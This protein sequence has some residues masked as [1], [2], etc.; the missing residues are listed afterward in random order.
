MREI[1]SLPS[2]EDALTNQAFKLVLTSVELT[3]DELMQR[4]QEGHQSA[5]Q[6]L[7]DRHQ[8]ALLGFFFRQTR[9][10]QF[11]ED[12]TQETLL[13]VYN[14]HWDYLPRGAFRGWMFR[15]ARNLLI[16][17]IRRRHGDALVHSVRGESDDEDSLLSQKP[18]DEPTPDSKADIAEIAGLVDELLKQ[19]PEE[20]RLT[21]TMYHYMGLSLPEVADAME[22]NLA[23]TKS[24]LRLSREKLREKLA[25]H[26]ITSD[27]FE[28]PSE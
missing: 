22:S 9:D 21:F 13:R 16:D 28:E 20:Q 8:R 11:A 2:G 25:D 5:F 18:G 12:L 17:N 10:L 14:Q 15:I 3:D 19:L 6:V 1:L 23:T 26:G 24:R 7:V 27:V 4:L